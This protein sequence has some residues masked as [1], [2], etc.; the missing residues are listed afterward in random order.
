MVKVASTVKPRLSLLFAVLTSSNMLL[1]V[2]VCVFGVFGRAPS[3]RD[4]IGSRSV[5]ATQ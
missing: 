5:R 1:S 2:C 4:Q 3:P